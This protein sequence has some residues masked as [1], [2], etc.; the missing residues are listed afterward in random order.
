MELDREAPAMR[1]GTSPVGV[2]LDHRPCDVGLSGQLWTRRLAGE[3][4]A[5]RYRVRLTERGIKPNSP[6]RPSGS[7]SDATVSH[8]L[9]AAS[10]PYSHCSESAIAVV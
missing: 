5:K 9:F 2:I 4:I 3:L 7:S 1:A 10:L 8:T 6:P